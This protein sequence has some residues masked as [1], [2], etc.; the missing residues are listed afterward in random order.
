MKS[1]EECT[2]RMEELDNRDEI[3]QE[4]ERA[5]YEKLKKKFEGKDKK[6]RLEQLVKK[7]DLL[8]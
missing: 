8:K 3:K 4:E 2:K 7:V 6:E 5:L 1:E